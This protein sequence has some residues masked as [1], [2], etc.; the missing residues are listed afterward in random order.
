MN[1]KPL[2]NGPAFSRRDAR[3]SCPPSLPC[4]RLARRA[5]KSGIVRIQITAALP[6][7]SPSRLHTPSEG[8][9]LEAAHPRLAPCEK[10]AKTSA[11]RLH[12]ANKFCSSIEQIARSSRPCCAARYQFRRNLWISGRCRR[13]IRRFRR[14]RSGRS[15][16]GARSGARAVLPR[17]GRRVGARIRSG[18][19]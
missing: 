18:R 10:Q 3:R 7:T 13:G 2:K 14:G 9:L 11:R 6:S 16:A 4:Q 19:V 5:A 1:A 8:R 17:A 12:P 15:F